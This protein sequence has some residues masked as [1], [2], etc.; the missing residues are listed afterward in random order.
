MHNELNNK[1]PLRR[2]LGYVVLSVI[3]F[4][5]SLCAAWFVH[6]TVLEKRQQDTHFTVVALVQSC[7]S[8]DHLKTWQL[9]ELLELSRDRPTN[10]Y[11]FDTTLAAQ[12]LMSCPV[13]KRAICRRQRPGIVHVDYT[14]REPQA[15][16]SDVTN[17][18]IDQEGFTFPLRPYY[19]P[20]NLPELY[21]GNA[22]LHF[23]TKLNSAEATLAFAIVAFIKQSF[24][25][26]TKV[27]RV[28]THNAFAKSAGIREVIVVLQEM[29]EKSTRYLRFNGKNY[30]QALNEYRK[31]KVTFDGLQHNQ[32]PQIIDLRNP[33]IAL[34][35]QA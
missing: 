8:K 33:N 19:T 22:P 3:V 7:Q 25:T 35:K 2:A 21:L 10:L 15:V 31:L 9:A 26:A 12:K 34:V 17:L 24:P 28:D 14:L 20:K 23:A 29:P 32:E 1:I 18:A 30:V 6:R 5:G 4:W 16:L 11:A 13:I 27:V